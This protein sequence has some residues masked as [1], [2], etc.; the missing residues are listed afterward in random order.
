MQA[1]H[2]LTGLSARVRRIVS[3]P[4]RGF[5]QDPRGGLRRAL[6]P[7]IHATQK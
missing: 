1:S 6:H 2:F 3:D 7:Q 4:T 5:L